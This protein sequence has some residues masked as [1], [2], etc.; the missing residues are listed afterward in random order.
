MKKIL[1]QYGK[2]KIIEIY[3]VDHIDETGEKVYQINSVYYEVYTF[4]GI[5]QFPITDI[6]DAIVKPEEAGLPAHCVY[7][8]INKITYFYNPKIDLLN[9]QK[10]KPV[11]KN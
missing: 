7:D 11:F 4:I 9:G 3:H 10:V 8:N 5:R 1:L 6:F 2:N